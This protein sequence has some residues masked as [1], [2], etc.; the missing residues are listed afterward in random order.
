MMKLLKLVLAASAV[1]A[2]AD[3]ISRRL[4]VSTTNPIRARTAQDS[5][6]VP[7]LHP[8]GDP[9]VIADH[10]EYLSATTYQNRENSTGVLVVYR[11]RDE[12]EDTTKIAAAVTMDRGE[13]W[14]DHGEVHVEEDA[15][16]DLRWPTAVQFPS[17]K[18]LVAYWQQ[19]TD[20]GDGSKEDLIITD[21][22]AFSSSTDY[23]YTWD[24]LDPV[25]RKH[26]GDDGEPENLDLFSPYLWLSRDGTVQLYYAEGKRGDVLT[27]SISMMWSDDEGESW[28][29]RDDDSHIVAHD[30]K[31]LNDRPRVLGWGDDVFCV[32]DSQET[33]PGSDGGTFFNTA[34]ANIVKSS[35]NGNTWE[36]AQELITAT[37]DRSVGYPHLVNVNGTL[38]LTAMTNLA[39]GEDG[40]G[41]KSMNVADL[42]LHI[43]GDA[44]QTWVE[45]TADGDVAAL[46]RDITNPFVH[47]LGAEKGEPNEVLLLWTALGD[48]KTAMSAKYELR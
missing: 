12:A 16:Q 9:T 19:T 34:S 47:F 25:E 14:K 28:K 15:Q 33:H 13:L 38:I 3:P 5:G 27:R 10:G 45:H 22:I 24:D 18:I 6:D 29:P 20:P 26:D 48:D 43:S 37:D 46:E 1:L 8:A 44:G 31:A 4:L 21:R 17:G 39:Y 32:F 40:Y 2:A 7:D 42:S 30:K 11:V 23:G 35:D 36:D 41:D